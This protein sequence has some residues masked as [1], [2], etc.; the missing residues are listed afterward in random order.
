M[1]VLSTRAW[2]IIL[3]VL[4]APVKRKM[5]SFGISVLSDLSWLQTA[6]NS[7]FDAFPVIDVTEKEKKMLYF[8]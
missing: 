1:N 4:R 8:Y 5:A 7:S 2:V 6:S 3:T